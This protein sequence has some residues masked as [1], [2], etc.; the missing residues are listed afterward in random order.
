MYNTEKNKKLNFLTSLL[1][2][3]NIEHYGDI[4]FN[5]EPKG[6]TATKPKGGAKG[7]QK[8][9]NKLDEYYNLDVS[10]PPKVKTY[11]QPTSDYRTNSRIIEKE[12]RLATIGG[13]KKKYDDIPKQ[14]MRGKLK[15]QSPEK[16]QSPPKNKQN[17]PW[18]TFVKSTMNE[19]GLSLKET[20]KYIKDN[21]LYKK[22]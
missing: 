12:Q 11:K 3:K 21:Q 16:K 19:Q 13:S 22:K 17:N 5:K 10:K 14:T 1:V 6:M 18:L 7:G 8:E 9:F 2:K 20:L 15:K 4:G